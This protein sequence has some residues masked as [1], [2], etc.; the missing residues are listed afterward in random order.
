MLFG[1]AG[2]GKTCTMR[3]ILDEDPPDKYTTTPLAVRP[4][5]VYPVDMTPS[6]WKKLS[7]KEQDLV[8]AKVCY[9]E[10][11][12]DLSQIPV[13][14][15]EAP[16]LQQPHS[17]TSSLVPHDKGGRRPYFCTTNVCR[18]N[19]HQQCFQ[20]RYCCSMIKR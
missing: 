5:K 11:A 12:V 18:C 16:Q 2:S 9:S 13:E 17:D 8:I 6:Q 20:P 15:H 1:C 4:V 10:E 14:L 7:R 19:S 3:A